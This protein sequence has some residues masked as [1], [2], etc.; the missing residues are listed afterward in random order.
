NYGWR[1]IL[2]VGAIAYVVMLACWP[3]AQQ[4]PILNPLHALNE[5]SDFPHNVEMLVD[6]KIYMSTELPR[7]YVPLYFGVQLPELLLLLLALAVLSLP[8]IWRDY[9]KVHREALVLSLSMGFAPILYAIIMHP[10]LYDAVR[11]FLFTVPLMCVFT[12]IA[13]HHAFTQ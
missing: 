1:A 5:F 8:W 2:P 4:N 9:D 13:A 6:G 11:H 10:P 12:A 3:W 7:S